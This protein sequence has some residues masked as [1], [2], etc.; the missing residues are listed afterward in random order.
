M[1][2]DQN[3]ENCE[4]AIFRVNILE[5]CEPGGSVSIMSGY[6]LDDRVFEVRSPA[7]SKEFFF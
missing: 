6:E 4:I 7:E 1:I 3:C 5:R 2:C